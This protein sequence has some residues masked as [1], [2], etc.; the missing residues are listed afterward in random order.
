MRTPCVCVATMVVSEMKERL[1]P[2]NE[3]PT[4]MATMRGTDMPVCSAMPTATGVSA[5]TVPT[6]VPMEREM[7]QAAMKRPGRSMLSG[8]RRRVKSTV[9]SM[10]PIALAALAKAPARMKIHTMS[11]RFSS[12]APREKS[13]MRCLSLSPRVMH[14]A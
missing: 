8:K 9:A 10:A 14:T 1:S 7:K 12:P 5:T 3:P 11:M 6:E 4:T 13:E 2:K